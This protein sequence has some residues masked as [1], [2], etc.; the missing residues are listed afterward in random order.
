MLYT[1]LIVF[2]FALVIILHEDLRLLKSRRIDVYSLSST[3]SVVTKLLFLLWVTGIGLLAIKP[4]LDPQLI[5]GD[6][7]LAAKLTVVTALTVNGLVL[8]LLVLPSFNHQ[9]NK[10]RIG[11][12]AFDASVFGAFSTVSWLFAGFVGSARIISP[13]MTFQSFMYLYG[14]LI[15]I[16]IIFSLA[17]V[18]PKL[19]KLLRASDFAVLERRL[20]LHFKKG[21]IAV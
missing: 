2:A 18:R 9:P 14:A 12:K 5:V 11:I 21:A 8:H 3:A 20:A 7:K 17:V 1:H 19:I 10:S 6:A 4:G 15:A 16:G 13:L